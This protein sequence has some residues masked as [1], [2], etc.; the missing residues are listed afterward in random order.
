[1]SAPLRVSALV[2]FA[3]VAGAPLFAQSTTVAPSARPTQER[4]LPSPFVRLADTV[5]VM[6][7][8]RVTAAGPAEEII[9]TLEGGD[10]GV[11]TTGGNDGR[12][13][14]V[15]RFAEPV[16]V[17]GRLRFGDGGQ[18]DEIAKFAP[19]GGNSKP[20]SCV[21]ERIRRSGI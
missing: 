16:S 12:A 20:S 6:A 17:F 19:G 9:V 10:F 7:E 3:G 2:A 18:F 8:G 21:S 14:D 11:N 15:C 13:V 4:V 1:M 5:V